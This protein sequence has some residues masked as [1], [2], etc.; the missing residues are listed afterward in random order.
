MIL[1]RITPMTAGEN[2][3][4]DPYI[5][6]LHIGHLRFI[7]FGAWAPLEVSILER[8]AVVNPFV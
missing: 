3:L 5:A 8:D 7:G 6:Q 1:G 4:R 2:E